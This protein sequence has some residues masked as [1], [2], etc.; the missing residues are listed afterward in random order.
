MDMTLRPATPAE[1]IYAVEQS[2]QIAGQ[3]GS[4][5]YLLGSLDKTGTTFLSSWARNVPD[6][7]TQEFKTEFDTVIDMLRFDVRYGLAL[8]NRAMM[9]AYC[10]DHSEGQLENG[11]EYVFRAD[12]RDY[13]YL[14]RC[15]PNGEDNH[16][17]IYP[18]RRE[19]LDR[20]MKQAEKGIRFLTPD[21]KEKFRIPDGESIQITTSGAGT[22]RNTARFVDN[23]HVLIV[24][25]YGSHLYHIHEFP[26]WL[27]RHDG[28][29]IPLRSSLPEKCFSITSSAD[30][31][32]TIT[33]GEM[34]HRPAGVHAEGMTAREGATAANEAMGVTKAQEAAMLYGSIYGWDKPA[35]DPDYYNEQGEPIKFKH[36]DRGDA[37]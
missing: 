19:L 37:R 4:P 36:R 24:T 7:N 16:V 8:K 18:Y 13:S 25:R 15:A 27:E 26:K 10:L 34:G 30:E 6:Q 17:Y 11:L 2:M 3:C 21:G 5:G 23:H 32:V 20:H 12:T 14:I 28:S 33:K 22:R 35:A 29:I 9:I 31:I 1:Q